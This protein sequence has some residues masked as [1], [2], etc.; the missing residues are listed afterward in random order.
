MV[1]AIDGDPVMRMAI[2]PEFGAAVEAA[3]G[4]GRNGRIAR[5]HQYSSAVAVIGKRERA[6]DWY[7]D[8]GRRYADLPSEERWERLVQ[9]WDRG[10]CPDGT[11]HRASV[12]KTLSPTAV[13]LPDAFFSEEGD[14]VFKPN[15]DGTAY[16]QVR[17]RPAS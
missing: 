6:A 15:D 14:R 11:Y 9:A 12:F 13:P 7:D 8:M 3:H 1:W 16:I 10:E 17:G 2:A 4:V 5:D